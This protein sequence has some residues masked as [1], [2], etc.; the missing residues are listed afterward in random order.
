MDPTESFHDLMARLCL[1]ED[2]AAADLHKRF[3][4]RL[5]ALAHTQFDTWVRAK[6]DHEDVV[7]SAFQSFFE[8]CGRGEFELAGWDSLWSLLALITVRKCRDRRKRLGARRRAVAR[9]RPWAKDVAGEV[10]AAPFDREPT[11]EQAAMLAELLVR[12]LASL[13]PAERSIVELGL[14]GLDDATVARHL[15][16]SQ[17]TVRRVRV[18]VEERLKSL[19]R[20]EPAD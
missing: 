3:V 16:R 18:Q 19:C 14:Q 11:P 1:G 8:H 17:R 6:A 5:V 4:C 2:A 20:G 15:S 9:E 13:E 7:Q 12:W 10:D